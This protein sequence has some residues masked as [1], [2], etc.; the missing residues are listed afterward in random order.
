M[1]RI[2][3]RKETEQKERPEHSDDVVGEAPVTQRPAAAQGEPRLQLGPEAESNR[4]GVSQ[5][6]ER[7]PGGAQSVEIRPGETENDRT[8]SDH[9]RC[10]KEALGRSPA[11]QPSG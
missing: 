8:R 5:R 2:K 6:P 1:H 4:D 7:G 10:T 11:D 3:E 9:E